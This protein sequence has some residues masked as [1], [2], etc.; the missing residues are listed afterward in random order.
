MQIAGFEK[1]LF[2]RKLEIDNNVPKSKLE[3]M[4]SGKLIKIS[5]PSRSLQLTL[6]LTYITASVLHQSA[7]AG[8]E[9]KSFS[10]LWVE[11]YWDIDGF[12]ELQP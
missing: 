8:S 2:I 10:K 12:F 3:N 4:K 7:S 11:I 9:T 5:L 6:I 1:P